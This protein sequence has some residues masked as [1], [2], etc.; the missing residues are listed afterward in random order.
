[1]V[2]GIKYEKFMHKL[3]VRKTSDTAGIFS[4]LIEEFFGEDKIWESKENFRKKKSEVHDGI[5]PNL[6]EYNE[7]CIE[8][9]EGKC[10]FL[11]YII[12]F[13]SLEQ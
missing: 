12:G 13:V 7:F 5:D 2:E 9:K 1:M 4:P 3:G 10:T 6:T 11:E 8:W